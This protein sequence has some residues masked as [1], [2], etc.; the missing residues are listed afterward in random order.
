MSRMPASTYE[1]P[2]YGQIM[3]FSTL[4]ICYYIFDS[5][6]AQKSSFKLQQQGDF[7]QRKAFPVVPWSV[8]EDPTYIQTKHGNKLLTSG[9]W[10]YVRKPNYSADWIQSV[11][12]GLSGGLV[13]PITMW[14][15]IFFLAVLVH[16]CERDFAKCSRKYGEDWDEYCRIVPYKFIPYVY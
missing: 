7:Y 12:W 13:T 1:F 15:P 10:G 3:M 4:L 14:Y 11:T 9:W 8:I 16:R 6:M 2:L 5:S